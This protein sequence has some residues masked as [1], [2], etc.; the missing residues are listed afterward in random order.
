MHAP[1]GKIAAR[2]A[3]ISVHLPETILDNET[4]SR[5]F[6]IWQADQIEAKLGIR[7]RRIAGPDET[8]GDLAVAAA[9]KLFASGAIERDQIDFLL[10]CTQTPDHAIPGV[11]CI[12][13]DRLGLSK[14]TGALDVALGCSGYVYCLSLAAGLIAAGAARRIL[15][16]TTDT[17]SKIIHP[18]DRS[19]RPLFGD[20]ATASLIEGDSDTRSHIGPFV[21]GTDGS[22]ARHLILEA[23]GTRL[24]RSKD[25]ARSREDASGVVRSADTLSM[26]G[27]AILAFTNRE[28][29]GSFDALLAKAEWSRDGI[30]RVI[31]HQANKFMLD[32]LAKK[33]RIPAE[34]LPHRFADTGNTVSSTIPIALAALHEEGLLKRGEKIVLL[35][36]GVG[37]SWAG[38]AL[39]W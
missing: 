12:V 30:N 24:P 20:G 9:E 35:G 33:L 1:P 32:T 2:I 17:Y 21:F 10:V 39:T 31:A 6:P 27:P 37:L 34:L 26:N 5:D 8:A 22:G 25:T 38:A 11:A 15:L 3:A 14:Q 7:E 29:P 4:L 36:F 18:G 19:V 28:V 23:G 16:I 13:Q